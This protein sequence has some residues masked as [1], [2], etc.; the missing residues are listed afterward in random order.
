MV[1]TL[2]RRRA[3]E[4]AGSYVCAAPQQNKP[5]LVTVEQRDAKRQ[6]RKTPVLVQVNRALQAA[7]IAMCGVA[8]LGY[9]FDVADSNK[10]GKAQEQVRRLSEQNSELS[11][12][13]LKVV[14]YQG[15]QDGLVGKSGLRVPEEVKIVPEVSAPKLIVFKPAKHHLPLM[16]SY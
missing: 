11:S 10:V 8:I 7:L 5:R 6:Q 3:N 12:N 9:G 4:P 16:S 14:S 15:L 13:L 1:N 2:P